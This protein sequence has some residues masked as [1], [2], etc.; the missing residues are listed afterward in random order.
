MT[1]RESH[2]FFTSLRDCI[3]WTA[4]LLSVVI[5][6]TIV[7]TWIT[8][9]VRGR[10]FSS[11]NG[12]VLGLVAFIGIGSVVVGLAIFFFG[13]LGRVT[14][15]PEGIEGP[16]YSGAHTFIAWSDMDRVEAGSLSGWPCAVVYARS[17]RTAIYVMVIGREKKTFV[18]SVL[19]HADSENPLFRYY[20]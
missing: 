17:K 19:Q 7:G 14:V 15:S 2:T 11:L 8:S 3:F 5:L 1:S 9:A 13:W 10:T 4:K 20:S 6:L 18:E 16:K 12:D